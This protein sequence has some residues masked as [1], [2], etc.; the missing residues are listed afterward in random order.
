MSVFTNPASRSR[1]Q[2]AAYTSAVLE[3]VG[4][5]DPF[6]ILESTPTALDTALAA[7]SPQRI[8]Q[9]EAAGKW[10]IRHVV[11]HL[12]DSELVWG[13]RLRM[14]L[15]QDRPPLTGYDQDAW[16]DR[17]RYEGADA[18]QALEEF[19]VLRRANLRILKAAPPGDLNRVGIHAERGEESVRH[20]M[21]LY[22][23]HDV[24]HLRQIDRIRHAVR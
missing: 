10:S 8:H 2:G 12:A 5:R 11:Q 24:L 19:V 16:A 14:V 6:E 23:G 1:E 20:M 21:R 17:L 9:P 22:A 15:A 3:L 4:D 13:Y 18:R 7:L